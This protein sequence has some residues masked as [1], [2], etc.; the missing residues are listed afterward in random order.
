MGQNLY[1]DPSSNDLAVDPTTSNLRIT[2]TWAEET[3]QRIQCALGVYRGEWWLDPSLGLPYFQ[4]IL[5]KAADTGR[6]R[7]LLLTAI[8]AVMGVSEVLEI[9]L[10][11]EAST[12]VLSVTFTVLLTTGEVINGGTSL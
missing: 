3:S 12:R 6:I 8:R 11:F 1:L 10:N 2:S 7:G 5:T 4:D 9:N